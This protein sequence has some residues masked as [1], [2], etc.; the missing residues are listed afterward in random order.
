[1]HDNTLTE[2]T[3]ARAYKIQAITAHIGATV[4]V[5]NLALGVLETLDGHF[6]GLLGRLGVTALTAAVWFSATHKA[7]LMRGR[8]TR[9]NPLELFRTPDAWLPSLAFDRAAV[10]DSHVQL[11]PPSSTTK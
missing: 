3:A 4:F 6:A 2:T 10:G 11:L 8:T 9:S 5:A 1:M 7:N